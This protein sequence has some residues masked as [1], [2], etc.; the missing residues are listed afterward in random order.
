MCR[1][2][3]WCK[4][5]AVVLLHHHT[6]CVCIFIICV[7]V[8]GRILQECPHCVLMFFTPQPAAGRR[9]TGWS[10]SWSVYR[11]HVLWYLQ[12]PRFSETLLWV[13]NKQQ[14]LLYTRINISIS[15]KTST[16]NNCLHASDISWISF[17]WRSVL[18][19]VT[20]SFHNSAVESWGKSLFMCPGWQVSRLLA[21]CP[22]KRLFPS[23]S[24]LCVHS[25]DS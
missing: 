18:H 6:H 21:H 25:K 4:H 12:H 1:W 3:I 8:F 19:W 11:K 2:N 13:N 9:H 22:Q 17:C 5:G 10:S 20:Y 7:A 24:L 16:P 15:S 14:H 23:I